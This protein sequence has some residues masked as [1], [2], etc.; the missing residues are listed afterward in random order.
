MA[1]DAVGGASIAISVKNKYPVESVKFLDYLY[2]DEMSDLFNFGIEGTHYTRVD[3]KPKFTDAM[4]KETDIQAILREAGGGSWPY[5]SSLEATNQLTTIP[6]T[7]T[8]R[9]MYEE[10]IVPAFP[11]LSLKYQPDKLNQLY[12]LFSA[13]STYQE[14]MYAKFIF[15]YEPIENYGAFVKELEKL[16]YQEMVDIVAEAY[17]R[18]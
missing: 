9:N 5:R 12:G 11:V 15:G 8:A 6:E 18:Y 10:L 4:L 14:Q 17:L 1:R 7:R 3:G 13:I 2:G 16:N